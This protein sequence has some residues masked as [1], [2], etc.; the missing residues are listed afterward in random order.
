VDHPI[1]PEWGGERF[2][3][4][5]RIAGHPDRW[6]F[7]LKPHAL[8]LAIGTRTSCTFD[9][10]GRL[11][12]AFADQ[13]NYRC[14]LDGRVLEKHS[15]A[16][17]GMEERYRRHLEAGAADALHARVHRDLERIATARRDGL[18]EVTAQE[19]DDALAGLDAWLPRLR[20]WSGPE[21][22]R[23]AARFH[24]L[25]QP[26]SV[27]PPD[28][29]LALVVQSTQGCPWNRCR[30]C[31]L[32]ADRPYRVRS[33]AELRAHLEGIAAFLGAG[34]RLRRSVFL[35]DGNM[36]AVSRPHLESTFAQV[37]QVLGPGPLTR[38]LYGFA[39]AMGVARHSAA[40]LDALGRQGLHRVYLGLETGCDELLG[41]LGKPGA[42]AESVAAVRR[43]RQAGVR[44]GV[45]VL[46]GAGGRRWAAAHERDTARALDAMAL[47]AGDL[48]FF[49]PLVAAP[50]SPYARQAGEE[51]F[52]P[53]EPAELAAQRRR[54][55]A[56]LRRPPEGPRAALYDI[57]DF[58]Y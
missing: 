6:L 49:S 23:D 44:A 56:V 8:S 32:Y 46:L 22:A 40:D 19:P 1:P 18:L 21:R 30:F 4:E 38:R 9:R 14:G 11:F 53:M 5:F 27:L 28:Q 10:E 58:V 16:A 55:Q 50:D 26:V 36:L 37:R 3:L 39:D 17:D 48:V 20:R 42:A 41:V 52:G 25:Y 29:Y 33:G 15:R 31:A 51:G 7:S 13:R 2:R 24:A 54:L 47:G 57:R 45:I 12:A 34:L 35:G 43:L